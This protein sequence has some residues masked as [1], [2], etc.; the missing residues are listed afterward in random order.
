[1]ALLAEDVVL[2]ALALDRWEIAAK[3]VGAA[4]ALREHLDAPRPPAVATALDA[5]THTRR[6][7]WLT[8]CA[9]AGQEG[10]DRREVVIGEAIQELAAL[11]LSVV[12]D[13]M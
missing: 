9:T 10:R 4:D 5:A 6:E 3:L 2:L 11:P 7:W 12:C 1:M 13:A 8:N